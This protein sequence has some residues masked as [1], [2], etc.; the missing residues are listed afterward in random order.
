MSW[1]QSGCGRPCSVG[2]KPEC[3]HAK[4]DQRDRPL[5]HRTQQFLQLQSRTPQLH[6]SSPHASSGRLQLQ[7]DHGWSRCRSKWVRVQRTDINAPQESWPSFHTASPC[8][9][10]ERRTRRSAQIRLTN[11]VAWVTCSI[12]RGIMPRLVLCVQ[13]VVPMVC[14]FPEPVYKHGHPMTTSVSPGHMQRCKCC[15]R[16]EPTER[17]G[18]SPRR[19]APVC[20]LVQ[21]P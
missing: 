14:V 5:P 21:T 18:R 17:A 6:P 3:L 11:T 20:S 4:E 2:R 15:S 9:E 12:A 13:S 8:S 7:A 10:A 19:P 1:Q 16:Q